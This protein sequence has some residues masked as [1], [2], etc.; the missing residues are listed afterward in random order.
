[1]R[2][3]L[4]TLSFFDLEDINDDDLMSYYRASDVLNDPRLTSDRKRA[5]LAYWAS[6]IHAVPNAPA[7]RS[8]AGGVTET[9]DDLFAAMK[10]LDGQVGAATLADGG[11]ATR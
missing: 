9:I 3:N 10:T 2:T 4:E 6:D 11:T 1:M 5:L 7:L 8:Y